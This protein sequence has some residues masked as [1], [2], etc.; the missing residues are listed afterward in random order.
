MKSWEKDLTR[1][2]WLDWMFVYLCGYCLIVHVIV[3]LNKEINVGNI[4]KE[5]KNVGKIYLFL[6]YNY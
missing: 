3:L 5:N 4:K 1:W 6:I 2:N